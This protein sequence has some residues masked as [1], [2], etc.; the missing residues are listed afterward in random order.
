M[1]DEAPGDTGLFGIVDDISAGDRKREATLIELIEPGLRRMIRSKIEW[2][3]VDDVVQ[4]VLLTLIQN[5]RAGQLKDSSRIL[6]YLRTI[7]IRAASSRCRSYVAGRRNPPIELCRNLADTS[8]SV[9]ARLD[10]SNR[11]K[12]LIRRLQQMPAKQRDVLYRFYVGNESKDQILADTGM[13]ETQFR[14]LKSRAKQ[15]L[16]R[17]CTGDLP[18]RWAGSLLASA[19]TFFV[20]PSA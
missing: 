4:E 14:L 5:L 17:K 1:Q 2:Y 15:S 8:E 6:G 12:I 11:Q 9:D 3:D 7:A 20:R 19:H 13:T 18:G 16:T 10:A